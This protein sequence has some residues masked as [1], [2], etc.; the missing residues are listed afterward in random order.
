MLH[1]PRRAAG[2]T[3]LEQGDL[4]G[5]AACPLTVS[6]IA[7]HRGLVAHELGAAGEL[8][9]RVGE[10]RRDVHR[11]ERPARLAGLER[12]PADHGDAPA[13]LDARVPQRLGESREPR[14]VDS[15]QAERRTADDVD[16]DRHDRRVHDALLADDQ[17]PPT[18]RE[19]QQRLLEPRI[20]PAQVLEA[21]GML[22]V[23]VHDDRVGL[24]RR[25]QPGDPPSYSSAEI[26]GRGPAGTS[27]GGT[28]ISATSIVDWVIPASV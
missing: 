17:R 25:E 21:A 13:A 27:T 23:G 4:V 20:E 28:P 22:T 1:H 5:R 19:H 8:A 7:Q 11:R 3:P 9:Q 18:A 10:E 2:R 6:G 15:H 14:P 12:L 24:D 16:V 26:S